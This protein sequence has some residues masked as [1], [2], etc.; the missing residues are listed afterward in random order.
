[1]FICDKCKKSSNPKEKQNKVT[2]KTRE[3]YYHYYKVKYKDF[4]R[5]KII[6]TENKHFA[7]DKDNKILKEWKSNG[8][9]IIKEINLCNKCYNK[10]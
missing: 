9:E 4:R 6:I 10:E 3:K 5:F 1:M 2:I 8:K 7:K